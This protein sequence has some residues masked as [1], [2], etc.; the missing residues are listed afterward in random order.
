MRTFDAVSCQ[1]AF[2]YCFEQKEAVRQALCN[3]SSCLKQNGLF[4]VTVPDSEVLFRR[5]KRA[6]A[7]GRN[8]FGNSVYTVR[9]E[10]T[11]EFLK[12]GQRYW[13]WLADAI[14]NCP[15]YM[16]HQKTLVDLALENHLELL[17]KRGFGDFYHQYEGKYKA[18]FRKM[19]HTPSRAE[20]QILSPEEWDAA[21]L[22]IA[23]VF[24]YTGGHSSPEAGSRRREAE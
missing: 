11:D 2:H 3:V 15:E 14:E 1:F 16:V 8:S 5:L 20:Q 12:Y 22:Y 19:V 9:F 24:R 7:Q 4:L 17:E 10:K 23:L 6:N 13:F 21:S 18:L